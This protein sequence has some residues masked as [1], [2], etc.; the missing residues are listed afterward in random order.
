MKQRARYRCTWRGEWCLCHADVTP[1]PSLVIV[2]NEHLD[3]PDVVGEF[4]RR[5]DGSPSDAIYLV[6][7]LK[8]RLNHSKLEESVS[9]PWATSA[10]Q[11]VLRRWS[12]QV[13][14]CTR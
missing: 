4:L 9:V 7:V 14:L 10:G 5:A 11:R 12:P 2:T 13:F 3:G 8:R 1:S 6:C